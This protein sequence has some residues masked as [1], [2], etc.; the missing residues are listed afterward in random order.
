MRYLT[1]AAALLAACVHPIPLTSAETCAIR[2]MA[3]GGVNVS[4]GGA[5]G[6]AYVNGRWIYAGASYGGETA[7]CVQPQP[8]QVCEVR[9]NLVS[10]ERKLD[11]GTGWRNLVIGVGYVA[12]ILPGLLF[13]VGFRQEAI[14]TRDGAQADGQA[15]YARCVR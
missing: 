7:I 9:A 13:Y 11:F 1:I 10:A 2:G 14:D 15:A 5:S 3:L 6:G 12:F 8:G 4:S